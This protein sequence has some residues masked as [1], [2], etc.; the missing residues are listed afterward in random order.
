[1]STRK[2]KRQAL[3]REEDDEH[4]ENAEQAGDKLLKD[5]AEKEREIWD[6]IREER[7]EIVEQL[8]LTLHR[9]LSL[10]RQLDQQSQ[11]IYVLNLSSFCQLCNATGYIEK[12]LPTLRDYMKLRHKLA[13]ETKDEEDD[14]VSLAKEDGGS[15]S[16]SSSTAIA[17]T[18]SM[19]A[20]SPSFTLSQTAPMPIPRERTRAPRTSRE[21]LSH[22]AWLS[23][24]LL[25]ASQEKANL[26]QATNDSVERHIRLLD[27]AIQEQQASL[28]SSTTGS[29]HLPDLTLPKPTRQTANALDKYN[30]ITLQTSGL[31]NDRADDESG[32]SPIEQVGIPRDVM[33]A[34]FVN[35]TKNEAGEDL[36]CYCN[37]VSFGEMIACDGPHCGLEWF[38]LGC[39]GLTEPPEGEWYCENCTKFDV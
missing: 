10:M 15:K 20:F 23:E 29:I 2:R 39:V 8:P 14:T 26:A 5:P 28:I 38:H 31:F 32:D 9:Q 34:M 12:L 36:Y 35:P 16:T 13:A 7:Y 4:E 3:H 33:K 17:P 27:L 19:D 1:M 24:E 11:G 6:A 37:R 22:I 21:H 18:T 25:R 30:S